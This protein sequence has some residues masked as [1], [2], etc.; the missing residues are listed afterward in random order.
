MDFI[1]GD[2]F[3]FRTTR[4]EGTGIKNLAIDSGNRYVYAATYFNPP[5]E[6]FHA[7]GNVFSLRTRVDGAP[8]APANGSWSE[9]ATGLPAYDPPD[10]ESLFP[11]HVLAFDDPTNPGAAYIGGEGISFNKAV[12]GLPVGIPEWNTSQAGL[13]NRIMTR[14]PILFT[15]PCA[16]TID[17]IDYDSD[18]GVYTYTVYVQDSNG[19][20]P[21]VGSTFTVDLLDFEGKVVSNLLKVDYPDAYVYAGTKRDP[22]NADTYDPFIIRANPLPFQKVRFSFVPLCLDVAPGC[23]G[24]AQ[25]IT[26]PY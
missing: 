3:T 16:M 22:A 11:Q 8:V 1:V 2:T 24:T 10:D 12:S 15:G 17:K 7:V 6:P 19:N 20:P 26:F 5:F 23:S 14:M 4:D 21:I 13:T 25:E 9:V 18:T